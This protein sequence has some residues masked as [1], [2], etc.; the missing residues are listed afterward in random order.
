MVNPPITGIPLGMSYSCSERIYVSTNDSIPGK[1]MTI[2]MEGVQ[3]RRYLAFSKSSSS[4]LCIG[5]FS[6]AKGDL[7]FEC[8]SYGR[9]M[10]VS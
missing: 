4:S 3:V 5:P 9:V 7:I 10:T 6:E 8:K 2:S 1:M